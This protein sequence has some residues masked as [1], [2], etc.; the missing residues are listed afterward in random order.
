MPFDEPRNFGAQQLA[1][2][3]TDEF[4]MFRQANIPSGEI[5]AS[6]L[7]LREGE[8][9]KAFTDDR[10]EQINEDV[11]K[12]RSDLD[13]PFDELYHKER[14]LVAD[15]IR[16]EKAIRAIEEKL[17]NPAEAMMFDPK[18]ID[19]DPVYGDLY[20]ADREPQFIKDKR[21]QER[22]EKKEGQ[23]HS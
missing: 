17:P 3:K 6:D 13:T 4:D 10:Q 5:T 11:A 9:P 14:K 21:A 23:L 8:P 16:A 20:N 2:A 15:I 12:V 18:D 19:E 22:A 7:A 1:Y